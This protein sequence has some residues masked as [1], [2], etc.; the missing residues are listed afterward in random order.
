MTTDQQPSD[1]RRRDFLRQVAAFA[2]GALLVPPLLDLD[3]VAAE[4]EPPA[5][6]A[7]PVLGVATGTDWSALPV[8]AMAALGGMQA[9]VKPGSTVVV[10]PNIGWDRT[11]EQGA[12]THPLVVASVVR[13]C[14]A[15]GAKT[16][17]VFDRTCNNRDKCYANSGIRAAVEAIADPRVQLTFPDDRKAI[18]V[19]IAQGKLITEWSLYREALECDHYINVPVA[20]H[21]GLS[22]LTL[23]IKNVMGIMA[24]NRGSIHQGIHQK[25]ADIYRARPATLTIL[26]AT[27]ILLRNGPQ[28]GKLEDVEVRNT[29]AA[30]ADPVAID[31][32]ATGLF[33][34]KPADIGYI[35]SAAEAGLGIMDLDRVRIVQA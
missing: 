32:W 23:G 18:P 7:R 10:K 13:M 15:A 31:A 6:D 11:P 5:A 4:A 35:A 9:F 3:A 29:V 34:L 27:R 30:C 2:A 28:G 26:D 16:V 19:R 1:P 22:R 24:G 33:G 21:H 20:K 12:N 8:T 17:R 25:L 14:L